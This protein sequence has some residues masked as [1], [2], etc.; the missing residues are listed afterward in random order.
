[1]S[2]AAQLLQAPAEHAAPQRR[3]SSFFLPMLLMPKARRHGLKALYYFCRAVDDAVDEAPNKAQAKTN[4][5]Y[6]RKEL[7][8]IYVPS[9]SPE[10]SVTIALN[11]A[12]QQYNLPRQPFEDLLSGME[13]DCQPQVA[14]RNEVELE[15]YCYCVAGSVGLQAMRIFG[16]VTSE[17][18]V[19][20][21]RLGQ[22][23]QLTNI[24]RDREKDAAIGRSYVPQDWREN[25]AEMLIEKAEANFT[26]VAEL[27]QVLPARPLLPALLMRDIYYQK[28]E[29]L[30]VGKT[31]QRPS[32]IWLFRRIFSYWFT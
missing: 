32:V 15:R 22:A 18:D 6:W 14:I 3:K 12:V 29:A 23:L 8:A 2:S 25:A 30:R 4:L 26:V 13:F 10:D 19:F 27:E 24:L 21:K 20:A 7:E 17:G 31:S 9:S 5:A 1:M 28:L 11:N 16:V